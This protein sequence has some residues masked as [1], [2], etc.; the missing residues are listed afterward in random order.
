MFSNINF[1]SW[2]KFPKVSHLGEIVPDSTDKVHASIQSVDSLILPRGQGRSYGDSCLN[3]G[4]YLLSTKLLNKFINFD[5]DIGI[6]RC[7]SGITLDEILKVFVPKGWF[8]TVT[9]GTKFVTVGG[10]IANDVHGKN[11]HRSGSFGNHIVRFELLRSDGTR[12]L[13]SK[14]NNYDWFKA[15][16]GGLGLTGVILWAE[17]KLKPIKGPYIE[18]E[19]IKFESLDEFFSISHENNYEYTL[20]WL[21]CLNNVVRGIFMGGNHSDRVENDL[22]KAVHKDYAWKTFPIDAPSFLMSKNNIKLFNVLYYNKQRKKHKKNIV[23]YDLFFYPLDNIN[24]INRMYGKKGFLQ[25]QCVVPVSEKNE[26]LRSILKEIL[27]SKLGSFVAVFK[28]FGN[29]P[30]MGMLSFPKPGVTLAVEFPNVGKQLLD[31]LNKLDEVVVDS[32]GRIYPAKDARM[33][34]KTFQSSFPELETFVK[35]VD[36]KFSSSF[37]RRVTEG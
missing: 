31:F 18:M 12:I 2:G 30:P 11:H 23:H 15:T 20:S 17:L 26:A 8:P 27:E 6:L 25:W 24:H 34:S 9:P 21:D 5:P 19:S 3:E 37:Y 28:E 4:G 10:A 22:S 7:E 33:S 29:L 32:G 13:C 36:P 14:D 1:E 35:Y 16:I